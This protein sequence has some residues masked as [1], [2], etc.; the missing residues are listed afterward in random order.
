M[1]VLRCTLF[2]LFICCNSLLAQ[3]EPLNP[4]KFNVIPPSP[5]AASLGRYGE[6]PVNLFNGLPNIEIPLSQIAVGSEFNMPVN[7]SYH[8]AGNRVDEIA[9]YV[10]LGWALNAGGAITR[11]VHGSP[12]E[13]GYLGQGHGKLIPADRPWQMDASNFQRFRSSALG[14]IDTQPDEFSYNFGGYSG[15]FVVDTNGVVQLM[16]YKNIRVKWDWATG[17][18]FTVTTENGTKYIFKATDITWVTSNCGDSY[19]SYTSAWYLTTIILPV[20]KRT[21]NFEYISGSVSINSTS[22]TESRNACY[23]GNCGGIQG[24]PGITPVLTSCVTTRSYTQQQIKKIEYPGGRISFNYAFPRTDEGT[25]QYALSDITVSSNV[26]GVYTDVNKYKL[27]YVTPDRLKLQSVSTVDMNDNVISAYKL[28]YEQTP[29]PAIN[30]KSKDHWG[31]YNNASNTTLIPADKDLGLPGGN[32]APN[33]QYTKAGILE[34]IEYPTGGSTT[35]EFE[36]HTYSYYGGGGAVEDPIYQPISVGK[37]VATSPKDRGP[38]SDTIKL[39]FSKELHVGVSAIVRSCC[40]NIAT[41]VAVNMATGERRYITSTT[42]DLYFSAGQH[43]IILDAEHSE[44]TIYDELAYVSITYGVFVGYTYIGTASGLRIRKI[45]TYDG[46]NHVNDIIK[47]YTYNFGSD[48]LS[49]GYLCN[50]PKYN[51]SYVAMKPVKNSDGTNTPNYPCPLTIRTSAPNNEIESGQGSVVYREVLESIGSNKQNGS[52]RYIYKLDNNASGLNIYPFGPT[53]NV[54]ITNGMLERQLTFDNTGKR[55]AETIN[56]YDTFEKGNVRGWKTGYSEKG[57]NFTGPA[58]EKFATNTYDYKSAGVLLKKTTQKQYLG[59]GELTNVTE[60]TYDNL[61][62]IQPT[63][64]HKVTS[65]MND[66]WIYNKYPTD[67]TIPSGA[68]SAGLQAL[69]FMQDSNMHNAMIEQYTQQVAGGATTTLSAAQVQYKILPVAN[70]QSAVMTSAYKLSTPEP[71]TNFVPAYILNNDLKR[72]NNYEQVLNFNLYDNNG[73]IQEQ[74]KTNDINEVY[75]WGYNDLYPV[76]KII[77]STYQTAISYV[78]PAVIRN[79]QSDVQLR[80]E[81]DKIRTGLKGTNALVSTYTYKPAVG[82][83]SET[84]PSGK[85]VYYEY[86]NVGRLLL[87]KDQNGKILKQYSYQYQQPVNQ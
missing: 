40:G 9:S 66:L 26:G 72:D 67:Y 20:S 87:I 32:R 68:L 45:T 60:Y 74:S 56:E 54:N 61:Q 21:I 46:I 77:G 19:D 11:T 80:A 35:F 10:G 38:K 36:N 82:V 18:S 53:P 22:E 55:V 15:K 8:A 69:K 58:L 52:I 16:P 28:Y 2:L 41:A 57:F 85:I 59:T 12:D 27:N 17:S 39:N 79:P 83:T 33:S 37:A 29:L 4:T 76:A 51:Y 3:E 75:I 50:R 44:E 25:G 73:N 62:H 24:C 84:D 5:N 70:N 43:L 13:Y 49:S 71:L 7:L 48:T 78:D 34:K 1:K 47:T 65:K 30:A 14:I 86:D 31:Y 42:K 81:L 63:R 6:T 64:I 23:G